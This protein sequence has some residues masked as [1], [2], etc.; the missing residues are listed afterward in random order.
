[1]TNKYIKDGIFD[2]KFIGN[3]PFEAGT[4]M[5][6]K[7]VLCDKTSSYQE[8]L[9][10]DSIN[11]GRVLVL[12]GIIQ[13]TSSDEFAYH[14]MLS[15]TPLSCH[16]NPERVLVVGGGD[17]GLLKQILK[18]PSVKQITLCDIDKVVIEQCKLYFSNLTSSFNDGRCTLVIGDAFDYLKKCESESFDVVIC[19]C[20]DPDGDSGIS[21]RLFGEEFYTHVRRV[22]SKKGIVCSQTA[23][24]M[25]QFAEI[26]KGLIEICKPLYPVIGMSYVSVPAYSCGQ[27]G[28]LICSKDGDQDL[29][30]PYW[31]FTEQKLDALDLNYYETDLHRMCFNLPRFIRKSLFSENTNGRAHTIEVDTNED[32]C[33]I[34]NEKVQTKFQNIPDKKLVAV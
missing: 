14:E 8:I 34:E 17:G 11:H 1:M 27:N 22:L 2:E 31:K 32:S 13:M 18:F 20:T 33:R 7:E 28:F 12:D 29:R 9:I 3:S 15:F 26:A 23:N 6:V 24:N 10:F 19:D 25:W 30:E 21:E 16:P 4:G 5:Y